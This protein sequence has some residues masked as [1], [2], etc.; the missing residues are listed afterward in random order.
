VSDLKVTQH[1][2]KVIRNG[3]RLV[4]RIWNAY[5]FLCNVSYCA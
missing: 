4:Q 5:I 1:I 2:R 3:L